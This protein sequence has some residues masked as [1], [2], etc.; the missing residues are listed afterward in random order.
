MPPEPNTNDFDSVLKYL[1]SSKEQAQ[2]AAQLYEVGNLPNLEEHEKIFPETFYYIA[3]LGEQR[4]EYL[5]QNVE[6]IFGINPE[7]GVKMPVIEFFNRVTT[8]KEMSEALQILQD[9]MEF[10][11]SL[12]IE[13]LKDLR[14][15]RC[16]RLRGQD[17]KFRKVIDQCTILSYTSNQTISRY[18]GAVSLAPLIS[19]FSVS[20]GVVIDISNGEE[21]VR[22]NT[23]VAQESISSLTKREV[24]ILRLLAMGNR[25][26]QVADKL[27]ISV[28]TVQTHRK[29]IMSKLDISN[30]VELVWKAIELKVV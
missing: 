11:R 29:R 12:P 28:Q 5:S 1:Q 10:T 9:Y 26:Q 13:K 25:N 18:F 8:P 21:L 30:P 27:F 19:E 15:L 23:S 6:N 7:E 14:L 20:T 16:S 2:S 24:Q 3:N 4:Y 17:G 22:F